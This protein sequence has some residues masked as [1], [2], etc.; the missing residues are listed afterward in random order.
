MT[1]RLVCFFAL[2]TLLITFAAASAQPALPLPKPIIGA[3]M[4]SLSPDGKRLAFVYKGDI[5][6]A[7]ANGGRAMTLTR[8]VEFDGYPRFSPDGNWIAFSTTRNG[9][10]DIYIVPALGGEVKRLTWHSSG[11]IACGWSPDGKQI[12]FGG[13]R[14]TTDP[15]LLSIDVDSLRLHKLAQDYF[16]IGDASYSPDGKTILYSRSGFPWFRPRY[17]GSGSSRTWVLDV[18]SGKRRGV[19]DDDRQHIWPRWLPDGKHFAVVTVGEVT[20]SARNIKDTKPEIFADSPAR[21]PNLW[22]YNLEGNGK[23]ITHFTGGSVRYPCVAAQTGDIAFEYDKD[24]WLLRAGSKTPEKIAL[25][26]SEDDAQNSFRHEVLSTGASEAEP[27]PDGKTFAF[28]IKGEIWTVT[29]DK[30]KGV[31]GKDKELARRLTTWAGDDSDFS[32]SADGNKLYFRSNREH[33]SKVF[34]M[35]LATLEVKSIWKRPERVGGLKLSA[36]G[37]QLAFWAIGPERGLYILPLDTLVPRRL[38]RVPDDTPGWQDGGDVAWSPDYK[39]I[40]YSWR[41]VN[42][43]VNLW[44]IPAEGGKAI[45]V[46]KLNASHGQPVWSPDGKYLFFQSNRD[47]DAIYVLPLTREQARLG[48]WDIKFEKPKDPV[49]VEIDFT[50]ITRRIRKFCSQDSDGDLTITA[51]GK[52]YFL[53]AGDIWT[54]SYD[55]KDTKRITNGGGRGFLRISKDGKKLYNTKNGDLYITSITPA[56]TIEKDEKIEFKADWEHDI[57]ADRAA[58]FDQFWQAFSDEFYDNNMHGRDW[59]AIR[60]RYEPLLEAVETRDEFATLLS[61]MVGELESSHSEVGAAGGGPPSQST[62]WLGF[63]FDYS[64]DG[65]GL[66]VDKVPFGAPGSFEKSK[67]NPGDYILTINNKAVTLDENLFKMI[68]DQG[69]R[70]FEFLVNAKPTRDGART[71]R[72][73]APG[74]GEWYD[75]AYR[76]RVERLKKYVETKSDGKIGYVHV[77]GM[78]WGNQ[79]QF[80]REFYEYSLDKSAMIIDVRFNGGGNISD[81][82]IDWMERKVHGYYRDRDAETHTAPGRTWEKPT[83]VLMN[84]HSMSNAEMFPYAMRAR[85]L[86]KLVG[87]PTPGYVIWTG[88]FQLVDGTNARMPGSGVYRLDGSPME[89]MGEQPDV[90]VPM[91]PEDWL[92]ERDPQLDKALEMLMH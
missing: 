35:N 45:N 69:G 38:I 48:E 31:E 90:K 18:A 28:G 77:G 4:P 68:N 88:G 56:D 43:A 32:W 10:W 29:T 84:E 44:I 19:L 58:S 87:M 51:D 7:D 24:L 70:E 8:N 65:P 41:E 76:N 52:I 13:N 75:I 86:A 59:L 80:E 60:K 62:P 40:A 5:W 74:W 72:Y 53:S 23:Q 91:S 30:P 42:G 17:N 64:Y 22:V 73:A 89:D 34:E 20:P 16:S 26:A 9:H 1:R 63:T 49:K 2:L 12:L 66:R 27:S 83:I 6:V 54:V 78:G 11:V 47:G 25:I 92:A 82:L 81:T 3:R 55:G 15:E 85:G 39:W 50:D 37:K 21:T 61:M 46:T 36:D 33:I 14:D 67:I 79:Q 57:H 71:V